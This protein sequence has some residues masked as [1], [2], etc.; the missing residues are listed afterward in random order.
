MIQ[1]WLFFSRF[2]RAAVTATTR[3]FSSWP[4]STASRTSGP[5]TAWTDSL[6]VSCSLDETRRRLEKWN[7]KS[8]RDKFKSN[9]SAVSKENFRSKKIDVFLLLLMMMMMLLLSMM[10]FCSAA[11]IRDV[12]AVDFVCWCC[13]YCCWYCC[14]F[15]C[16]RCCCCCMNV[17][18]LI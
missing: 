4:R 6:P 15:C 5:S 9:T 14:Y 10:L 16:C 12:A 2:T 1:N 13:C 8:G 18:N 3:S 11:V 7:N 17:I